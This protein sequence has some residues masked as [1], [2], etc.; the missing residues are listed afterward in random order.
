MG[1]GNTLPIIIAA[2][3]NKEQVHALVVVLKRLK[4]VISWTIADIIG[5]P[6]EICTHKIQLEDDCCPS[7]EH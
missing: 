3:L 7:M 6:P 2:D 1:E 5:I 4:K